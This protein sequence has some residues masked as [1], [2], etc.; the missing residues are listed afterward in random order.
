[1]VKTRIPSELA[2]DLLS[3]VE[4]RFGGFPLTRNWGLRLRELAPG[5][6]RLT[7]VPNEHTTNG[8][9]GV[10]NGGVLATL[11]D[12]ACA[13][14]LCTCFDGR[15]P[16]ATSDLHIRYLEPADSEITVEATVVRASLR[17]AVLDCRMLC[18][19]RIVATS[20]AHFII[21]LRAKEVQ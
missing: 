21:K 13:F 19:G 5:S 6:A 12:M 17:S 7:M 20:T 4:E 15:M 16:F 3:R 1:M 10:L 14:A 18:G 8:A 11:S 9:S 2:P